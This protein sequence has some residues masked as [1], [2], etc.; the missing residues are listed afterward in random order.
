MKKSQITLLALNVSV[1]SLLASTSVVHAEVYKG[2][3]DCVDTC[4]PWILYDGLYIGAAV[5]YDA[6]R[7]V[8]KVSDDG[9]LSDPGTGVA[10][11]EDP[12]LSANGIVGGIFAGYGKYFRDFHGVNPYLAL[13]LFVNATSADE[14]H[15]TAEKF[16]PGDVRRILNTTY[17]AKNNYGISLLPGIKVSDYTLLYVRLGYNWSEM[18]ID[19]SFLNTDAPRGKRNRNHI[20]VQL[21][22]GDEEETQ[23]GFNYGIG[24]ESAFYDNL[25]ARLEFTHTDYGSFKSDADTK[26][27]A[28]DNQM[29]L[30]VIYHFNF[31]K[32][33]HGLI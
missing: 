28:A 2:Y 11:S 10:F 23:G 22:D 20:S 4:S 5:G 9:F 30:S 12:R 18:S 19:E 14:D 7:V 17:T 26:V 27:T 21:G 13:E 32:I 24:V 8:D 31:A 15:E 16:S 1:A 25:S 6:Y 3:K 33:F 29:M